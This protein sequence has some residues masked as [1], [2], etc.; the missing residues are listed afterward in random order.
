MTIFI[1]MQIFFNKNDYFFRHEPYINHNKT[2]IMLHH[3]VANS[4]QV[5][6][7]EVI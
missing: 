5:F 7:N 1:V 3:F 4:L 2:V 6:S